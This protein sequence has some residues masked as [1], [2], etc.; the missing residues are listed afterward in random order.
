MHKKK[1]LLCLLIIAT[2]LIG[3]CFV[4]WPTRINQEM[5]GAELSADGTVLEECTITVKGWKLSY[6][7]QEDKIKLDTFQMN[8]PKTLDLHSQECSTLHGGISEKFV[9]SSWLAYTSKFQP[10]SLYFA[11]D[12][13]WILFITD[14]RYFAVSVDGSLSPESIW[15]T[16]TSV[17]NFG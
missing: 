2:L 7:F 17:I 15:E 4:P 10:V 13:S 12:N 16:V 3:V 1:I 14:D 11:N 6:L 8:T 9:F 5:T